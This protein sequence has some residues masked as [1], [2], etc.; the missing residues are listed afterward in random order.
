MNYQNNENQYLFGYGSLISEN[1]RRRTVDTDKAI[2]ALVSGYTRSWSYKCPRRDFT[3]VSVQHSNN[4][5]DTINGVLIKLVDP[6]NDLLKLDIREKNYARGIIS[7][8]TIKFLQG[9]SYPIEKNAIIWVYENQTK[10]KLN[11]SSTSQNHI[12]QE[13]FPSFD[14]PI[15]ASYIDCILKG[16][17]KYSYEFALLFV[18]ST[19]GFSYEHYLND[20][21]Y[22]VINRKYCAEDNEGL[23]EVVD[24]VLKES[25]DLAWTF[26]E[27]VDR[28]LKNSITRTL[29]S[30]SLSLVSLI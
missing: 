12:Q 13:H 15:P 10:E 25:T 20:R 5:S 1:S 11:Y 9:H 22:E 24:K 27:V 4:A 23:G 21:D 7:V 6:H 14:C 3:A 17:L 26:N 19:K 16:C 28:L 30:R 2:P 18:F 8:D 29:S